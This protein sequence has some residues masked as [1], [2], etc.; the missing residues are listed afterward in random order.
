MLNWTPNPL[1]AATTDHR[2]WPQGKRR[3]W[4]RQPEARIAHLHAELVHSPAEFSRGATAL[5]QHWRRQ[6]PHDP[7]PPVRTIG[8]SLRDLGLSQPRLP[9]ER[10]GAARYLCYP[11][12]SIHQVRGTRVLEIDCIGKKFLPGR[13]APL[14]F[15]GFAFKYPPKLRYFVR[16]PAETGAAVIHQ[17]AQFFQTFEIPDALTMENGF[18]MAGSAPQPRVLNKVPLW[19]LQHQVLPI[20]AVPRQP[21]SQASIEGNNSVFARKFW[22]SQHF[23]SVE[24]VDALLPFFN[25]ASLRYTQDA[26]PSQAPQAGSPPFRPTI[27]FLRQV[28]EV[29]GTAVIALVNDTVPLPHEFIKSFVFAEWDL[30]REALQISIEQDQTPV[31]IDTI[32]FHLNPTSKDKLQEAQVI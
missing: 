14:N 23:E 15:M 16:L 10:K 29:D 8:Q 13:T 28:Q 6:Y 25:Q 19:L 17:M 7:P 31:V 22:K 26:P 30:R 12:Y 2:G 5:Q 3:K 18:A 1:L 21:F 32:E 27:S 11:E 24:Q 4:D 9:R 20:Y